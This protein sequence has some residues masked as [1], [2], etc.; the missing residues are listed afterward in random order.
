MKK[1]DAG[2]AYTD[3]AARCYGEDRPHRFTEEE[4]KAYYWEVIW[5][6]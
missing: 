4:E 3:I 2:Q 6:R 1:V 5:R